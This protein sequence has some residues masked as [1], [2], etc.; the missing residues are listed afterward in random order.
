MKKLL[1]FIAVCACVRATL[2][3]P[4]F[5]EAAS[6]VTLDATKTF[7]LRV[8]KAPQTGDVSLL[9]ALSA[10]VDDTF[11]P[12]VTLNGVTATKETHAPLATWLPGFDATP[13]RSPRETREIQAGYRYAFPL[14]AL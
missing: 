3:E 6:P 4:V 12:T 1:V 7:E 11:R 5:W 10:P 13:I 14:S 2:A 9:V 8:G